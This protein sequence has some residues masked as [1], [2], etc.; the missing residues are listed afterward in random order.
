MCRLQP[1]L[2]M[3]VFIVLNVLCDETVKPSGRKSHWHHLSALWDR[4]NEDVC[5][6][7]LH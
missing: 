4:E 1:D 2:R 6:P 7:L 5:T 3:S